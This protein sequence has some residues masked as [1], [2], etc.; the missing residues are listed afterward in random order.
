MPQFEDVLHARCMPDFPHVA[1]G[2]LQSNS[3]K[4]RGVAKG[5]AFLGVGRVAWSEP[6]RGFVQKQDLNASSQHHREPVQSWSNVF[7]PLGS[8]ILG[9]EASSGSKLK[10]QLK[11]QGAK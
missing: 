1:A 10:P 5:R 6:I 4:E 9:A 2:K 7:P 8:M 3:S 11:L